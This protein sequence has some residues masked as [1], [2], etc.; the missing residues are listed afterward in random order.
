M[1]FKIGDVVG[2]FILRG[3]HISSSDP[4]R[5]LQRKKQLKDGKWKMTPNGF[6]SPVGGTLN[7]FVYSA[8]KNNIPDILKIV[9]VDGNILGVKRY[10][11][12][13]CDGKHALEWYYEEKTYTYKIEQKYVKPLTYFTKECLIK[14]FRNFP[15]TEPP[16]LKKSKKEII[17]F[18]ISVHDEVFNEA[19]RLTDIR[20]R[21]HEQYLED[22]KSGKLF[23]ELREEA[24][25]FIRNLEFNNETQFYLQMLRWRKI[26]YEDYMCHKEK[27]G[28]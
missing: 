23:E 26:Y 7:G 12:D 28:A 5:I 3:V 9:S 27:Q 19:Q 24:I 4:K 20:M 2:S 14:M 11:W 16:S 22:E 18:L 1:N 10:F 17:S 25:E 13:Y 21:E 15:N 6:F 8:N